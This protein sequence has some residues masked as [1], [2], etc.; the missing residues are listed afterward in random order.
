MAIADVYDAIIS[1]R[2]YKEGHSHEKAVEIILAG[3]G[4][5]FDPQLIDAFGE[6]HETFRSIAEQFV[7]ANVHKSIHSTT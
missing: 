5:Q 3:R 2:P 1:N 6:I 7:D 4:S